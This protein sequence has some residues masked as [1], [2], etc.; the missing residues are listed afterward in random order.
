M[1]T[2][3]NTSVPTVA[4]PEEAWEKILLPL[5]DDAKQRG[6]ERYG[7]QWRD[8][9]SPKDT[10]EYRAWHGIQVHVMARLAQVPELVERGQY[11]AAYA[12]LASTSY[13]FAVIVAQ[14]EWLLQH[15]TA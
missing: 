9:L 3:M 1:S 12:L 2:R 5:V 8:T 4:S 11:Q 7:D 14:I 15:R 6:R 10:A 13:H